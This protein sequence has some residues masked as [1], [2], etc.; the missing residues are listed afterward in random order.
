MAVGGTAI[1]TTGCSGTENIVKVAKDN[2]MIGI[3]QQFGTQV[4]TQN[5][6]IELAKL[7]QNRLSIS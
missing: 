7:V 5:Q 1:G 2:N 6:L 4:C 3:S